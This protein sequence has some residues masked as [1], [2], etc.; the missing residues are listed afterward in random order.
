MK[1]TSS[2][3]LICL[4]A[5][6]LAAD[7]ARAGAPDLAEQAAEDI[8]SSLS[9]QPAAKEV[10]ADHN[11]AQPP[12]LLM[13]QSVAAPVSSQP[14]PV[15]VES[16]HGRVQI[17]GKAARTELLFGLSNPSADSF[18][19]RVL[20]LI[21]SEARL[22]DEQQQGQ[23]GNRKQA[24]A[25]ASDR[26]QTLVRQ[27]IDG[28][29]QQLST[30][31]LPAQA[32]LSA[33]M[34]MPGQSRRNVLLSYQQPLVQAPGRL[35]YLLP[36]SGL[37]SN[38]VPLALEADVR[39]DSAIG[40]VY[41]PTHETYYVRIAPDRLLVRLA[42]GSANTPGTVQLS[43]L[44]IGPDDQGLAATL[45]T[46]RQD[47]Q[48]GHFLLVL[49]AGPELAAQRSKTREVTLVLDRSGST[50]SG[51]LDLSRRMALD[52]LGQLGPEDSF[53]II[54][55]ANTVSQLSSKPLAATDAN[56]ERARAYLQTLKSEGGTNF[57]AALAAAMAQPKSDAAVAAVLM[58]TDGVPSQG[59]IDESRIVES[60]SQANHAGRRVYPLALGD[61]VN[62][63][64]LDSLA[65]AHRGRAI[66]LTRQNQLK[67]DQWKP[68]VQPFYEGI[69]P[70]AISQVQVRAEDERIYQ[71]LPAGPVDLP[72]DQPVV[73]AGRYRGDKPLDLTILARLAGKDVTFT[74][75]FDVRA[76]V[77][78]GFV[79]RIWSRRRIAD[80]LGR[81]RQAQAL[82][83]GK[84][85]LAKP[86]GQEESDP[87]T[88]RMLDEIV[89]LS[90]RFGAITEYTQF[91][92]DDRINPAA[93]QAIADQAEQN[94]LRMLRDNRVGQSGTVQV[95]NQ[96][97]LSRQKTLNPR[98]NY[99]D[100]LFNIVAPAGVQPVNDLAMFRFG[101]AW[102]DS[103]A[104][105]EGLSRPEQIILRGS[106]AY[107]Q[108]VQQMAGQGRASAMALSGDLI[109]QNNKQQNVLIIDQPQSLTP[110]L[111]D[112]AFENSRSLKLESTDGQGE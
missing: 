58:I 89:R 10:R 51:G 97:N 6:A 5:V 46:Y 4:P 63:A 69:Q 18:P 75:S 106:E 14:G 111:L 64:L 48:D 77:A 44:P 2:L 41:S 12:L 36:R 105:A 99:V 1:H 84:F 45:Y 70:P 24:Q 103:R 23:A 100:G 68:S 34:D 49:A 85:R 72:V 67:Q 53:N 110:D 50:V 19:V 8:K 78:D 66:F 60:L 43:V 11:Q 31:F 102:V 52:V 109:L 39:S 112:A 91:L 80:L 7:V 57:Q 82:E 47:G 92:A 90:L 32:V 108:M 61:E 54:D 27:E 25:I 93:R 16:L 107:W 42:A 86:A 20:G 40:G 104:L 21:P 73:I 94:F 83:P 65:R 95:I 38:G 88:R 62:A 9:P 28:R 17:A 71:L 55:Y 13:G 15:M 98:N 29:A 87:Q 76:D 37:L 81:L 59:I 35:D 3:L 74:R 79:A 26:W 30:E 33:T 22:A 96:E 101:S 56:R